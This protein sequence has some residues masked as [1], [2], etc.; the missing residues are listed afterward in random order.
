MIGYALDCS[1]LPGVSYHGRLAM[2]VLFILT[3]AV[4]AGAVAGLGILNLVHARLIM[5]LQAAPAVTLDEQ[6]TCE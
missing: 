2:I 6:G 4:L 5:G 3:L 1:I